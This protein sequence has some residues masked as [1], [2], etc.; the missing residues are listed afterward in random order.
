M[1]VTTAR[2]RVLA[3]L[4]KS[5]RASARE[6]ARTLRMSEAAVRHHLRVLASD[7]R[8]TVDTVR[9]EGRGRPQKVFGISAALAGDNLAGL[10]EALLS[11][12]GENLQVERLAMRMLDTD[13]LANLPASKR[14]TLLVEKLN[15]MHYQSRWE[16]GAEGP[17]VIFGR[18]PYAAVIER[19]PKLCQ[20]DAEIL[21]RALGGAARQ[22]E[23]MERG[24]GVCIFSVR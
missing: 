13:P 1:S 18:C 7:G 15:S 2:Q 4:S 9:A 23:K 16:A 22:V 5:G 14:L 3:Q 12:E 24:R 19:H 6:L 17:R 21:T 8:V 20:M 10:V 11:M